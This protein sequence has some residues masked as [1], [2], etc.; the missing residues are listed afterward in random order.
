MLIL[1]V[2][3]LGA[4]LLYRCSEQELEN[5][6]SQEHQEQSSSETGHHSCCST[7]KVTVFKVI[8]DIF[9]CCFTSIERIS[10][11]RTAFMRTDTCVISTEDVPAAVADITFSAGTLQLIQT[12][13]KSGITRLSLIQVINWITADYGNSSSQGNEDCSVLH[14]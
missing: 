10:H 6:G 14:Y 3:A 5:K 7:P 4:A 2:Y 11:Y 8:R 1:Q 13:P 9:H 12:A